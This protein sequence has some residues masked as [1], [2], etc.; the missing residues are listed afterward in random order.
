MNRTE[1]A[2]ILRAMSRIHPDPVIIGSQ[3]ILGTY[4]SQE[5]PK[6]VTNSTEVDIAFLDDDE[7]RTK[8][9]TAVG[10]V[11][12]EMSPFHDMYGVYAEA[13]H[14]STA[15]LPQGWQERLIP[16]TLTGAEHVASRFLDAHDLVASKLAAGREKDHTFCSALLDAELVDIDILRDRAAR[17]PTDRVARAQ[18]WI[19]TYVRRHPR[20]PMTKSQRVI[21]VRSRSG[22]LFVAKLSYRGDEVHQIIEL[23]LDSR[24]PTWKP[25]MSADENR[26][27]YILDLA[28]RTP[29]DERTVPVDAA[30]RYGDAHGRCVVCSRPLT[31]PDS[32]FKGYGPVCASRVR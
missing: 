13:I 6:I 30:K 15:C 17:L 16:K 9:E 12:D 2:K 22:R 25:P 21:G 10:G 5:L 29:P 27:K 23:D 4:D 11:V 3:A 8:A 26:A 32:T 28:K 31:D 19:D 1:L 24:R 20:Y 14:I 7:S 18:S